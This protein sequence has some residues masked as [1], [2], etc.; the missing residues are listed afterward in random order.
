MEDYSTITQKNLGAEI[1]HKKY[2]KQIDWRRNNMRELYL[3]DDILN[4]RS[5]VLCTSVSLLFLETSILL[6]NRILVRKKEKTLLTVT[7]MNNRTLWMV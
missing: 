2:Q 4:M 6:E 5:L 1:T 3:S 7:I